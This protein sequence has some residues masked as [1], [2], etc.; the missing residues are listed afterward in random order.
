MPAYDYLCNACG[1]Q[2]ETRQKMS[3]PEIASC[4]EC[5]GAVKRLIGG[6]AGVIS[7][8]GSS[9]PQAASQCGAGSPCGV[10]GGCPNQQFCHPN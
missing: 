8:G 7:K 4:P 2:F 6:G 9:F 5:G 3:D 10:Q 1:R